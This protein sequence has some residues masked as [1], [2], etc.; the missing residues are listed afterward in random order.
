MPD[1]QNCYSVSNLNNKIRFLL[2]SELSD[3]WVQGEISNFHHHPSSSHMYFILKDNNSELRCAMFKANSQSLDFRPADGMA[4]RLFGRVTNYEQRGQVQLIVSKMVPEGE[5]EFLKAFEVL[6]KALAQE[7][8]FDIEHKI[9]LPSYPNTVGIITSKS[10][11]VF[12]DIL[13]VLSRRA[14][15]VKVLIKSVRVQGADAAEQIVSAIKLFNDYGDPDVLIIGRGG[16]SIEDLWAFNEEN[17]A[18]AI[19]NSSIPIISAVG[20]DTDYT[21]ADFVSDLRA[22]TPS[23]AAELAVPSVDKILVRLSETENR[24]INLI[25]NQLEQYWMIKDQLDK[26]ILNQ[27]PKMKIQKQSEQVFQFD[28]RLKHSINRIKIR[29]KDRIAFLKKQI[30]NLGPEQVL[31]RG[32]AIPFDK[33]GQIIRSADQISVGDTFSLKISKGVFNAKKISDI[34]NK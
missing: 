24:L 29:N 9:S 18:R 3:I 11:S 27:Q 25:K 33:I 5:G 14:P 6:K 32:Y 2:E 10:G 30:I 4:V 31:D 7:G 19:F 34:S 8:L 20:H 13:N 21:I 12:Q 16:G 22:P 17:V 26:R 28:Q 15:N 23:A 1:Y